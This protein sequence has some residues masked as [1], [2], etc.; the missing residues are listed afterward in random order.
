MTVDE[1]ADRE[2]KRAVTMPGVLLRVE[3]AL[4]A[5]G[6]IA[7]YVHLRGPWWL[8]LL[9]ALTPDLSMLGY[10]AGPRIG[11]VTYN[12]VHTYLLPGALVA[13]GL[14]F[15]VRG[16]LLVALIWL[17]HI[18]VDRLLTYGLKYPTAFQDSHLGRV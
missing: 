2:T 16:A 11:A 5:A 6:A 15:D 9:L 10:L 12:V 8:F 1:L 3:G 13:A 18:G 17:A 4:V 14:I 7:A